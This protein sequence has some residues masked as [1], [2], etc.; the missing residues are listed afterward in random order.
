MNPKHW[1]PNLK[2]HQTLNWK[3]ILKRKIELTKESK[4][5]NKIQENEDQ[6][7]KNKTK[8]IDLKMKLKTNKNLIKE[9]KIK[10][11]NQNIEILTLNIIKLWI[12]G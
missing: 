10:I 7:L 11:W 4:T 3:V 12:K 9:L 5:K 6:T 1:G 2:Y 8:I